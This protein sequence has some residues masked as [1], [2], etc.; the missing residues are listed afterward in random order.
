MFSPEIVCSDEFLDMPISS[1]DLYYQL[2]MRADDD[3]FI[4]PRSVMRQVGSSN[5]DLKVLLSKR[6]LLT[7]ESGVVVIKHWLIHNMIRGDRYKPTRFQEEKKV[8]F[9]K[10]NK[11]YTDWQPNG[12]QMAPQV[13]LGKVR[14]DIS[15]SKESGNKIPLENNENNM[16]WKKPYNE[17]EHSD[18]SVYIDAELNESI[19]PLEEKLKAEERELNTKIRAN[20]KL[21]EPIRGIPFGIGKD[22]NFHVK[23]YRELLSNGWSHKSIIATFLE[24]AESPH[25]KEKKEHGEYAGMNT[26][27]FHLRNKKPV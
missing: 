26:I 25:W 4:Q 15:D 3:G 2:G 21:V 23:I 5:D 20:L 17:N 22:M 9:I 19:E 13:R 7:F 8:L 1:R 6:F 24:I 14:L 12:N 18:D 27:Q 10:E 11:A 16:S